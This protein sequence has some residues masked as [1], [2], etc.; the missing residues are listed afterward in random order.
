MEKE[1]KKE[2]SLVHTMESKNTSLFTPAII[3]F[4]TFIAVLGIG[5]GYFL[6]KNK[7]TVL[8]GGTATS[9]K[10]VE[11]GKVEKGTTYGSNDTKTF[12]DSTEGT[13]QEGGKEDEG[14]YHLVRPGGE[15]QYVYMTSS[16]VDLSKFVGRKVKVW[17]ET[18]KAQK[19]G[20]LMDV[21]RIEVLE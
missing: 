14:Q 5:T 2:P 3:V 9:T 17:G 19:V 7:P 20:W 6:A 4:L 1:E 13:L 12:K 18:Q 15:S 16:L 8:P 11:G 21:G 10:S